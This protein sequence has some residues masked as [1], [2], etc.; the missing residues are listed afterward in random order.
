MVYVDQLRHYK[1]RLWCHLTADT[2][3]ELHRFA[4]QL[5][6][7]RRWFQDKGYKWHYDL[8][9][10]SREHAVAMG[11]REITSRD[12]VRL[13]QRRKEQRLAASSM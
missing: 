6:L 5:G 1:G 11:A 9:P 3:R 12:M 4:G 2:E 13:M 7:E 10:S 8:Q